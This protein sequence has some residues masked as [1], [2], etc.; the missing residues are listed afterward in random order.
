MLSMARGQ[1]PRL[2]SLLALSACLVP[3]ACTSADPGPIDDTTLP[4]Y[5][6]RSVQRLAP[7]VFAAV[8][9]DSTIYPFFAN[10]VF[11]VGDAGVTVIDPGATRRE[12]LGLL[13]AIRRVTDRPVRHV[14]NTH[15]HWDHVGGSRLFADSF[16]DVEVIA[17]GATAERVPTDTQS[18]LG[19]EVIR[20][21][22]RQERLNRWMVR[23]ETDDGEALTAA[24]HEEIASV[25]ARD[26][27]TIAALEETRLFVPTTVVDDR[28]ALVSSIP[29]E[30]LSVG[31]AHTSGDLVAH[32]PD[33]GIL[34]MGDLIEYGAPYFGHGSVSA[35]E[36]VLN[37]LAQLGASIHLPGHGPVPTGTRLFDAQRLL[38][39][40]LKGVA[41]SGDSGL[42]PAE[43][44]ADWDPK[45]YLDALPH[46]S[47][48]ELRAHAESL[49]ASLR[50]S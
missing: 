26:S 44:L 29:I 30:L 32:L 14:V 11:V 41:D 10:A 34:V 17:S 3:A 50:D 43:L 42:S 38:L 47:P 9:A 36:R 23:G 37:D 46:A 28:H 1:V 4:G 48:D 15:W 5:G 22:E 27:T 39:S 35:T 20:L 13:A 6:P 31:L 45:P 21:N 12:G 8:V 24:N 40:E 33:Q 7:G 18:Q 16:P 2:R 19:D 25:L 49:L